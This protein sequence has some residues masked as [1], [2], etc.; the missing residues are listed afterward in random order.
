[1]SQEHGK[2]L[3]RRQEKKWRFDAWQNRWC[4]RSN[5]SS[6][7][8][9]QNHLAPDQKQREGNEIN[10]PQEKWAQSNSES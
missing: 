8:W 2:R 3:K 4:L 7:T 5:C 6:W 9:Y 10:E 1:M